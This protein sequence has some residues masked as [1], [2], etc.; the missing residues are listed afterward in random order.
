VK[1]VRDRIVAGQ[2]VRRMSIAALLLTL[3]D[4]GCASNN[5][6]TVVNSPTSERP[7][8]SGITLPESLLAGQSTTL[9]VHWNP[10]CAESFDHA[11]VAQDSA[12]NLTVE[13]RTLVNHV[14]GCLGGTT[15]W[16]ENAITILVPA[17]GAQTVTVVGER[18]SIVFQLAANLPPPGARH[19]VDVVSRGGG[20]PLANV[21]LTY[22]QSFDPIDTLGTTTTGVDGRAEWV[23][24]CSMG[25]DSLTYLTP[26]ESDRNHWRD[27]VVFHGPYALC[28]RATRTILLYDSPP[29]ATGWPSS[30]ATYSSGS[31]WWRKPATIAFR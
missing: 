1:P 18:D 16:R 30:A 3:S 7:W 8:L 2:M 28:G 19:V 9:W 4:S 17:V 14:D 29:G 26:A 5:P 21:A 24:R 20:V 6:F 27:V 23:P 31:P 12:G 22:F 11:D 15:E 10:R 13:P 25:P